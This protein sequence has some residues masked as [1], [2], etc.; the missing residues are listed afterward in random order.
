MR[1]ALSLVFSLTVAFVYGQHYPYRQTISMLCSPQ[2]AGRG[3]VEEGRVLA[4]NFIASEFHK[5]GLKPFKKKFKSKFETL[6]IWKEITKKKR[7]WMDGPMD[8][9]SHG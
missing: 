7:T 1:L 4:A 5:I 6:L 2:Y 9:W 3:Y 8:E